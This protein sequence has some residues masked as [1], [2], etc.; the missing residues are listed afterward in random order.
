[1]TGADEDIVEGSTPGS[2]GWLTGRRRWFTASAL[3]AAV[4]LVGGLWW[5]QAG[6]G[7]PGSTEAGWTSHSVD[8]YWRFVNR[9]YGS[10]GYTNPPTT[11]ER[12]E[13]IA[14]EGLAL[15]QAPSGV[16][17]DALFMMP[18]SHKN[19]FTKPS[20]DKASELFN[21]AWQRA[22]QAATDATKGGP[23]ACEKNQEKVVRLTG[24]ATMFLGQPP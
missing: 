14:A 15:P 16:L 9:L 18:T 1:V 20:P 2:A 10:L 21:T 13:A 23:K 3:L 6:D 5:L 8:D 11:C 17:T 7:E 19:I 22:M 24:Q 12:L 4:C